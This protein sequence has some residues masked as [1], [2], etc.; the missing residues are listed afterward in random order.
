MCVYIYICLF[1]GAACPTI[2]KVPNVMVIH[3]EGE[4]TLEHMKV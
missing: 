4:G 1:S 2:A 3:G